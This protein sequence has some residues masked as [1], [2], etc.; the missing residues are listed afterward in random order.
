M[1]SMNGSTTDNRPS[2][3]DNPQST[4]A[5]R[6]SV[7]SRAYIPLGHLAKIDMVPG[8]PMISSENAQ[9]RSIVFLNVRGRD[10]GSFVNEAKD[11]LD[12]ELKLPQGY[13]LHWSG[14]WENQ[15]R[16]K[17]RLTMLMPIV[18]GLCLRTV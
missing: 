1:S 17:E 15:I 8:P 14:Q 12:K 9:L 5:Q 10:M 3:I 11:V 4:I 6:A 18:L 7:S 16:A 2:T 13:T